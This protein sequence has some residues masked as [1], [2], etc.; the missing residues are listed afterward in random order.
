MPLPADE[1]G[2]A[3]ASRPETSVP[4]DVENSGGA[5][6]A[7]IVEVPDVKP[8]GHDDIAVPVINRCGPRVCRHR[9]QHLLAR[10]YD[11]VNFQPAAGMQLGRMDTVCRHCG[12]L[13][14]PSEVKGACCHQGKVWLDFL[15]PPRDELIE[16]LTPGR[17][18]YREFRRQNLRDNTAFQPASIDCRVVRQEDWRQTFIVQ[19]K[20]CHRRSLART[21]RRGAV[22]A[23][24]SMLLGTTAFFHWDFD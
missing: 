10:N 11:P 1:V 14:W 23:A 16:L 5:G 3:A 8:Q 21:R 18:L 19:G 17:E 24:L 13:H 22:H 12:A 2:E 6:D 15:P 9:D 4:P 20:V 7:A